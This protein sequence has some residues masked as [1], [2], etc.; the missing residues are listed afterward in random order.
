MLSNKPAYQYMNTKIPS[1]NDI[2]LTILVILGFVLMPFGRSVE[3][4]TALL[5]LAGIYYVLKTSKFS[6][7]SIPAARLYVLLFMLIWVPTLVSAIDSTDFKRS[8]IF[9]ILYLRYLFAGLVV[10]YLFQQR[11]LKKWV[12]LSLCVVVLVW[13]S[14]SFIQWL[15]GVDL[16]GREYIGGRL[17]G[18]FDKLI[19]PIYLSVLLPFTLLYVAQ[20]TNAWGFLLILVMSLWVLLLAGGR[21]SFFVLLLAGLLYLFYQFISQQKKSWLLS[22][23]FIGIFIVGGIVAYHQSPMVEARV[24]KTALV[25]KGDYE[26]ID[27]A[28]SYRLP[29]WKTAYTMGL[30][31]L[32]NG[33]G[34]KNFRQGFQYYASAGNKY[35]KIGAMHPHLF[36]L[37]TFAETGLI[38]VL[39]SLLIPLVLFRFYTGNIRSMPPTHA[40]SMITVLVVFFP[41][42]A[43]VSFYGS[44]Y[45]QVAWV[46]VAISCACLGDDELA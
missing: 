25:F 14:D 2:T 42:N 46:M 1:K 32:F 34:V 37:E 20:K 17:T 23:L 7:S 31:H 22:M 36:F 6:L 38:G 27:K 8:I 21:A 45:S 10:I 9:C 29:L 4:T 28:T 26:S 15:F 30:D 3:V 19:L 39:G 35:E 44:V 18:P 13:V 24:D 12:L 11:E 41:F 33:Y 40:V 16:L 5:M 43:H